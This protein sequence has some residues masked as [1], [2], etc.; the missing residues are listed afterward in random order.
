MRKLII[1]MIAVITVATAFA[2]CTSGGNVSSSNGG[3]SSSM[4]S[5]PMSSQAT[6]APMSNNVTSAMSGVIGNQSNVV[7]SGVS[8]V[9]S[10][11]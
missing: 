9:S 10:A 6:S 11:S 3:V 4:T 8:S 1:M 5:A 2:S 7:G